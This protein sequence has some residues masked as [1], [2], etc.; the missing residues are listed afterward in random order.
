MTRGDSESTTEDIAEG[1]YDVAMLERAGIR[2]EDAN[3]Q[4]A[5]RIKAPGCLSL[6]NA[7]TVAH[8][9][10]RDATLVIGADEDFD[11]L[12]VEVELFRCRD[13]PV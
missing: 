13:G 2:I 10:S 12:P 3:W 4:Q 9:V 7:F 1:I 5:G 11:E 8:A 6:G